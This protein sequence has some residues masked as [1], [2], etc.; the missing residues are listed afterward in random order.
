MNI[1]Y[2]LKLILQM[3]FVKILTDKSIIVDVVVF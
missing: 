1:F 3:E 2:L